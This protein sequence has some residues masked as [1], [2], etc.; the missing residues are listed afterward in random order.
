MTTPQFIAHA[1]QISGQS[2]TTFFGAWLYHEG[3]PTSW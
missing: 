3:K 2:L 1:K